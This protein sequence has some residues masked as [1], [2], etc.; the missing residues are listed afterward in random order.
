[1]NVALIEPN[2][3]NYIRYSYKM[4]LM[5]STSSTSL[6]FNGVRVNSTLWRELLTFTPFELSV[7]SS[8]GLILHVENTMEA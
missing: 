7:M 6:H 4:S 8:E 3:M 5:W 2:D 1:M